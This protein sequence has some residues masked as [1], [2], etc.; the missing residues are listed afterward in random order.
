MRKARYEIYKCCLKEK[1][2]L[3]VRTISCDYV[4]KCS[5][6]CFM[7]PPAEGCPYST[8]CPVLCFWWLTCFGHSDPWWEGPVCAPFI[9]MPSFPSKRNQSVSE[10]GSWGVL[11]SSSWSRW[12]GEE[13][14][15]VCSTACLQ[16]GPREK[17]GA[18]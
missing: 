14:G 2:F 1:S 16:R 11:Q 8:G 3:P 17:E 12:L 4:C 7:I 5:T 6:L 13:S 10:G 18:C 15:R 9:H